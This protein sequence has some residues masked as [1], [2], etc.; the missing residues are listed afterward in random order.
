[1]VIVSVDLPKDGAPQ[2]RQV[3]PAFPVAI[4]RAYSLGHGGNDA[5]KTIASSLD[6]R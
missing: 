4:G 3:F 2:G 1:M 6:A 5:Q